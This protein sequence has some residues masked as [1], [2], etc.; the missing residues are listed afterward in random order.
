VGTGSPESGGENNGGPVTLLPGTAGLEAGLSSQHHTVWLYMD[1]LEATMLAAAQR[2]AKLDLL[3]L[4]GSGGMVPPLLYADDTTLLATSAD[5][6]QRALA[7]AGR[8]ATHPAPAVA[9]PRWPRAGRPPQPTPRQLHP[10]K[11]PRS[12]AAPPAQLPARQLGNRGAG[13]AS[14]CFCRTWGGAL[15]RWRSWQP[16]SPM[17]YWWLRPGRLCPAWKGSAASSRRSD[18]AQQQAA[19]AWRSFGLIGCQRK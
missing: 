5:G 13:P 9:R 2:G 17:A 12:C 11:P 19:V 3:W 7:A 6:L 8:Q 1:D 4:R 16:T 10:A 18:R 15:A 14:P